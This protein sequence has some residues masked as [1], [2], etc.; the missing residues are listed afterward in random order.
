VRLKKGV[1]YTQI[2]KQKEMK[3]QIL[4]SGCQNCLSLE[5][6]VKKIVKDLKI[7]AEIEHITDINKMVA[8]GMMMSPG[9]A[10]DG[11]LVSQGKIPEPEEIKKWLQ[12]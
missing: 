2:R 5:E 9:L 3:I 12:P 10:I 6:K 7:E 4:G 11:K 1:W 8:M